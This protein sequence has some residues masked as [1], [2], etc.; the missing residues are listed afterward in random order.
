MNEQKNSINGEI[1]E[2]AFAAAI[3]AFSDSTTCDSKYVPTWIERGLRDFSNLLNAM[4]SIY[5]A[6]KRIRNLEQTIEAEVECIRS[7]AERMKI[8]PD[9]LL[10]MVEDNIKKL[11]KEK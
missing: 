1:V 3:K 11:Q 10:A 6:R 2:S 4:F 8:D 7:I 9:T 5:F